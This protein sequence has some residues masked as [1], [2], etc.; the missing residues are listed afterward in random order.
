MLTLEMQGRKW[1]IF[2]S[3]VGL[4]SEYGYENVTVREIAA[5]NGMRA[6]SLYNHFPSKE[7][8]LDQI[9]QF[10][11]V[12]IMNVAPDL[13]EILALVPER[14]PRETLHL[15]MSYF[16]EEL[17][18][19]ME[20]ISLIA[21][22]RAHRDAAA[23]ELMWNY[24]AEH[25]KGYLRQVLQRMVDCDKIVP[26][27]IDSFLELFISFAYMTVLRNSSPAALGL[28]RW[29]KTLDTLFSLVKEKPQPA[30]NKGPDA[31]LIS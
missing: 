5:A 23:H 13:D 18:P 25:A 11:R 28:E 9:Y 31:K 12:N 27:D 26:L 3:S 1:D 21:I 14:S 15:T 2:V 16:D 7:S 19:I 4:F 20:K 17:Q 24:N 8:I 30:H 6:A 10:Y 29:L 22:M